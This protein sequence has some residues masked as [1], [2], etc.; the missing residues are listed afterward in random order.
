MVYHILP[1]IIDGAHV[2]LIAGKRGNILE[3]TA[4]D[5]GCATSPIG[6]AGSSSLALVG[7]AAS[8]VALVRR[9]RR[10]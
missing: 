6:V 8:V 10:A 1:D 3:P 2:F 4:D 7:L 5:G 9:R